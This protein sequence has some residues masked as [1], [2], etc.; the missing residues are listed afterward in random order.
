MSREAIFNAAL[1]RLGALSGV[2]VASRRLI[3][4]ETITVAQ[5]PALFLFPETE[6]VQTPGLNLPALR[7]YHALVAIYNNV[8]PSDLNV[9]PETAVNGVLDALARRMGRLR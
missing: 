7:R 6:D 5:S 2:V 9:Y 1:T 3:P 8:G 4:P